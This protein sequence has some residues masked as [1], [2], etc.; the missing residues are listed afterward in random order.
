[1]ARRIHD[2]D[3]PDRFVAGAIGQPGARTFYLQAR[4]GPQ[5]V[6]V[7]LEKAQV[8]VL[9]ERLLALLAE[10]RR[11]RAGAAG[12]GPLLESEPSS[13]A[14]GSGDPATELVELRPGAP[15]TAGGTSSSGDPERWRLE[16][17]VEEAFR[18]GTLSLTWD[19]SRPEVVIEAL[20][21]TDDE[22]AE[23][24]L[25]E[26]IDRPTREW[27]DD[28]PSGP[29]LLRVHLT[30]EAADRFARAAQ[31]VVAAGRPPC[32]LCG[33]PLDPQGHLCPRR[34]GHTPRLN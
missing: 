19:G 26:A 14:V 6:S 29:D 9:A 5:L 28:D 1:M 21:L 22:V 30:A 4:H 15:L 17:P 25:E 11:R 31:G 16:E 27:A 23:E 20:S 2:F 8:A 18:A 34:N 7:A 32:P 24:S 13:Q 10:V 33:Q 3:P 12:P